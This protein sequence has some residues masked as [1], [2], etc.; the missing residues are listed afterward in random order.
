MVWGCD[1]CCQMDHWG[2]RRS[3][4][5]QLDGES[6]LALNCNGECTIWIAVGSYCKLVSI[7]IWWSLQLGST[8]TVA[9]IQKSS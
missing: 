8:I 3:K 7:C 4:S 6:E 5:W 9:I 1:K 2:G